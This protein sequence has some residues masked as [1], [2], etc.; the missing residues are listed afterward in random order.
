MMYTRGVSPLVL[1][2]SDDDQFVIV[3]KGGEIANMFL[4]LIEIYSREGFTN[5]LLFFKGLF[6]FII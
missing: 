3:Y 1:T 6:T 2:S 5:I 4:C